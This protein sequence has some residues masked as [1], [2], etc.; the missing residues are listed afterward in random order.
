LSITPSPWHLLAYS[1]PTIK[2][3]L[4]VSHR[5]KP[6]FKL[7]KHQ[8]LGIKA[9]VTLNGTS[10]PYKNNGMPI[11]KNCGIEFSL[12]VSPK[13]LNGR[14]TVKWQVVNTG[15]EARRANNLRGGFETEINSTKRHERT[16][17]QGTHYVQA[18]LLKRGKCIA[19][20]KEFIVNIQ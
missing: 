14:Y 12:I 16:E 3:A 18:F 19:M 7:P 8:V 5:Q 11:P 13:L 15:D 20:S 17:Y 4:S 1:Y 6:P 2:N 10:Y 9:M